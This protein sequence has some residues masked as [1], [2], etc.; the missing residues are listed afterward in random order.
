MNWINEDIK[1]GGQTKK[2]QGG[3]KIKESARGGQF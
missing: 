2:R 3:G 1:R